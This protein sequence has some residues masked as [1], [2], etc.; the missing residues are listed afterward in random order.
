VKDRRIRLL[1]I[2]G[3]IFVAGLALNV[4]FYPHYAA[5]CTAILYVIVLQSLRHCVCGGRRREFRWRAVFP[6]SAS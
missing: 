2:A 1:L 3:P 6:R 5:P 4:W